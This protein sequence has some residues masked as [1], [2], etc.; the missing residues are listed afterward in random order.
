MEVDKVPFEVTAVSFHLGDDSS[1]GH[2]RTALWDG[3]VWYLLD[4]DAPPAATPVLPDK[5]LRNCC[6]LWLNSKNGGA[7]EIDVEL[8]T[9]AAGSPTP[10]SRDQMMMNLKHAFRMVVLGRPLG[11]RRSIVSMWVF[12]WNG[13]TYADTSSSIARCAACAH[14]TC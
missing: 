14:P 10:L 8:P 4:D 3:E 6:L 11:F 13:R 7:M 5:I 1:S 2:Y 9:E 12:F